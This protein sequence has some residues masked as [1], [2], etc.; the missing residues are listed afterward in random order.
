MSFQRVELGD[1]AEFVNGVAFKQEDWCDDGDRPIVRIQNLNDAKK[2]FNRTNRVVPDKNIARKGDLLV[3]WAASLGVYEWAGKDACVNQHIFKVLP[4]YDRVDHHYLRRVLD[5]SIQQMEAHAHGATM[6]HITRGKFLAVRIPLPPLPEQRRIAAIL[7]KAD[8]LRA[9]RRAAIAKLD[10]LLQSV[11]LDMFGDPVTNPKGWP[12]RELGDVCNVRDGTHESPK[13]VADGFPLVTSKNLASGHVNLK[14]A[15]L[16]SPEDYER[17]NRR[18][19]VSKGDILMPMIGTIGN[20]V[21]V[22]HN[23]EY[24]IKNVA[25][26]RFSKAAVSNVYVLH[27]LRSHFFA[28]VTTRR[29][30]G[31]TQKFLSLGAI[32]SMSIP[33]PVTEKQN[34]FEKWCSLLLAGRQKLELA[35]EKTSKLF[36]SL[37]QRAFSG[38]L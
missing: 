9:Q 18:S 13:Y 8:A 12:I 14:G 17:V 28:W 24:A 25:L 33:V 11:F 36:A 27:L 20:P 35:E 6:K 34:A 10:Q 22:D 16:I 7:D 4:K 15:M 5:A 23:P 2:P 1:V 29:N 3:S 32:R 19:R 37:Q 38:Q 31:G 30:R 21:L 26:L